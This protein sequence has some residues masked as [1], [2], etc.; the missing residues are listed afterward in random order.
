M[1]N[2]PPYNYDEDADDNYPP[3]NNYPPQEPI[4]INDPG[5]GGGAPTPPREGYPP[6]AGG[7]AYPPQQYPPSPPAND[8]YSGQTQSGSSYPPA[9]SGQIDIGSPYGE[10]SG[11]QGGGYQPPNQQPANYPPP[12]RDYP[13]QGGTYPPPNAGNIDLGAPVTPNRQARPSSPPPPDNGRID[14]GDVN[15][16]RP[17]R[18][19]DS[20]RRQQV[21]IG[22]DKPTPARPAAPTFVISERQVELLGWGITVVLFGLSL[23]ALAVGEPVVLWRVFPTVSGVVLLASATYQRMFRGWHVSV[24]TWLSAFVLIAYSITRYVD[25]E[26]RGSNFNF[27]EASIYFLGTLIILVG[28]GMLLRAFRRG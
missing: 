26:Q 16:G 2:R 20:G 6:Q 23:L 4:D 22:D 10:P 18:S 11:G 5:F 7:N 25:F 1:G 24:G 28:I 19:D 15:T 14:L 3:R 17:K 27:I 9:G 12:Q 13:P 21:D 8:P